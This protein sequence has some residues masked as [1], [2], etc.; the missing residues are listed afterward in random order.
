MIE[1]VHEMKVRERA[2][3]AGIVEDYFG[4]WKIAWIVSR[5]DQPNRYRLTAKMIDP[6][7]ECSAHEWNRLERIVI[8]FGAPTASIGEMPDD[9]AERKL[10]W[11]WTA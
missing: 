5:A 3:C 1:W 11:S 2:E 6:H 9:V 8:A 7:E 4:V 10:D